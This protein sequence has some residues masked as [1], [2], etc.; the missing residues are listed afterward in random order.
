M[1][2]ADRRLQ[3]GVAAENT[4]VEAVETG[5]VHVVDADGWAAGRRNDDYNEYLVAQSGRRVKKESPDE[6]R[7]GKPKERNMDK[8][9]HIEK[10][11]R[12]GAPRIDQ[13]DVS[14]P[15]PATPHATAPHPNAVPPDGLVEDVS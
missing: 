1:G 4:A 13:A 12:P 3:P 5:V 8:K 15:H 10:T 9:G 7:P 11:A 6:G 14:V 2:I